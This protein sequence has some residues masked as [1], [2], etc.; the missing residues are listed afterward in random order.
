M[1]MDECC[2]GH[3]VVNETCVL[4]IGWCIGREEKD[5]TFIDEGQ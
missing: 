2:E 4:V 5:S 3:A 1:N